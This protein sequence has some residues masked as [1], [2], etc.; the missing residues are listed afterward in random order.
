MALPSSRSSARHRSALGL[1]AAQENGPPA[2]RAGRLADGARIDGVL[3]E[4][5]W[6]AAEAI[7][8]LQANGSGRRRGAHRARTVVRVLAGARALVI[9]VVCDDSDPSGIVSFS[10]RRDAS[11]SSEDHVR[12]GA[13]TLSRWPVRLRVRRQPERRPLRRADQPGRRNRKRRLGRHL[14]SRHA[15]TDDGWSAEIRIP[16]QTLS[17]NPALREWH[18]NVQR[19]MQRRLETDRW[20]SPAR[21]Y[22]VTQTSRAGLLTDLPEFSLG[23]RPERPAGR[24]DRRR[25]SSAVAPRRGRVPAEPRRHAAAGRERARVADTS[26]PTSPK[27]RSIPAGRT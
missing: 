13:R 7:D 16:I 27:P 25:Y 24:D 20:A 11:L 10:V 22:Q 12:V 5:A 2:I 9:G 3:D 4:A 21:Q 26:T 18:F 19:R 1:Q 14:G 6:S 23:P 8:R 17:F 15:S